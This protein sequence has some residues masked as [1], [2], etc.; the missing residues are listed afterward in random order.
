MK[1]LQQ[2]SNNDTENKLAHITT[3]LNKAEEKGKESLSIK[4]IH[5][6][7]IQCIMKAYFPYD[8]PREIFERKLSIF[9]NIEEKN[10]VLN[11]QEQDLIDMFKRAYENIIDGKTNSFDLVDK[12]FK[13]YRYKLWINKE[14]EDGF[15][16]VR[17]KR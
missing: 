16:T 9:Y 3:L 11:K 4:F 6:L 5:S 13:N 12:K 17:R 1:T 2:L 10:L 14:D 15:K 7:R 8:L